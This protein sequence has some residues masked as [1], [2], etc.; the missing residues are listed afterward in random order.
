MGFLPALLVMLVVGAG[1]APGGGTAGP[2]VIPVIPPAAA[3][4]VDDLPMAI[5]WKAPDECPAVDE[6]KAD[7]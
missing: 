2:E 4:G 5:S 6:L 1:D 3:P 7:L